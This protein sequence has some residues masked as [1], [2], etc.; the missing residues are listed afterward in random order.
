MSYQFVSSFNGKETLEQLGKQGFDL[1]LLDL[2]LA[3]L[4]SFLFL[5]QI[6]C[7]SNTPI[8]VLSAKRD[9]A[10]RLRAFDEGADDFITKPFSSLKEVSLR[11]RAILAEPS[12]LS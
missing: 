10:V 6:R 2:C 3:D 7:L 1:V 5:R 8:I 4:N 9:E 11:I 12:H